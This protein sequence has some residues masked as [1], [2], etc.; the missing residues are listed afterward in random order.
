MGTEKKEFLALFDLDGTLFDTTQV[1][2]SAY[3]EALQPYGVK[4]DQAYFTEQY[5]GRH[6]TEFLPGLAGVGVDP[7]AVHAAK[8]AVY[9]KHLGKARANRQLFQMIET[10]QSKY[11]TAIV[12]TASR[13]NT[14]EILE[15]FQ[16][17]GY[18]E[19]LVTQEDVIKKKPDPEGFIRAM[20]YFGMDAQHT[21]I[22][23]DSD[24]GIA[25]AREVGAG[26]FVV[27]TYRSP[28]TT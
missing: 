3:Q 19:L 6:Y 13:K 14:C 9:G 12:T 1:N 26:V 17:S 8:K 5:N 21:I 25:A 18:F 4:L 27:D 22:F 16:Y 15:Y 10:M 28:H 2:Y 24:A 7:E 23:E 11:H 20:E